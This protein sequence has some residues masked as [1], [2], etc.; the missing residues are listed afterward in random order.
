[1]AADA[2]APLMGVQGGS[3][4]PGVAIS[5]LPPISSFSEEWAKDPRAVWSS[6]A[7]ILVSEI[8]DKT[9]LIA[10]ILAMRQYSF[11]VFLGA[12][13]ALALMSVLSAML[14]VVFPTLLP[15]TLTTFLASA[16]F[17]LFG[18][19]MLLEALKM[20]GDEMNEEWQEA[21]KEIDGE[22]DDV[23]AM[24]RLEDALDDEETKDS[25]IE[26]PM[27]VHGNVGSMRSSIHQRGSSVH[28]SRSGSPSRPRQSRLSEQGSLRE[29]ARNL[30]SLCFSR[31]FAQAFVL[32]FLGEWGDRSQ[33]ATIALAAAHNVALV[34]FGTIAG[35][36]ICTCAAVTA[37]SWLA[38]HISVKHVTLG[39]AALF[40]LFG[41]I[42]LY[43]SFL[44]IQD[45]NP[46]LAPSTMLNRSNTSLAA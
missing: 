29:G 44:Q 22:G 32:T 4:V 28:A 3:T 20:E 30:L 19:K 17:F 34:S 2:A 1:M 18:A 7:M 35:H 14:G 39:G 45:P 11:T 26:I 37:G 15:K 21:A 46:A 27:T 42:Y 31:T 33:I 23:Y 36:A 9:F 12:F 43:E 25:R 5:W 8:G 16:L 38:S 10:A 24:E 41:I 13:S 6:F 40:I